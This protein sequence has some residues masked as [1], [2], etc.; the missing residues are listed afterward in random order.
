MDA[1]FASYLAALQRRRRSGLTVKANVH[2]L[3]TLA[4]R[5]AE[6][7]LDARELT[8][9]DGELYFEDLL[10]RSAI[11]T[12]HRHLAVVRAAYRYALRHDL[13]ERDPT[14]DVKLPRLPDIE[15]VT[16]TNG[17]LRAIYAAIRSEREE[18]IFFL[19]AYAGL[20]LCEVTNLTWDRIDLPNEQIRLTGKGGKLRLVPLHPILEQV[21]RDHHGSARGQERHLIVTSQHHHELANRTCSALVRTLV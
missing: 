4:R 2:A 13:A 18:L 10:E 14:I 9:T 20:R 6:Q 16:Y 12:V 21:L 17:E 3:Q 5:L 15:P 1:I 19:L 7:G 11:A 8:L